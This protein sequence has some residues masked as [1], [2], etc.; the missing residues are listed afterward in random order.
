M[1][2]GERVY[3]RSESPQILTY[4][5]ARVYGMRPWRV[6]SHTAASDSLATKKGPYRPNLDLYWFD[7]NLQS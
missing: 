6:R 3:G 5:H 1:F 7:I 4:T 2:D